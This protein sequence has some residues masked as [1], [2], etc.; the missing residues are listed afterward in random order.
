VGVVVASFPRLFL[1]L[2][3][4]GNTWPQEEPLMDAPSRLGGAIPRFFLKID[5]YRQLKTPVCP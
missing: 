4:P 1:K 5:K 2:V 3:R